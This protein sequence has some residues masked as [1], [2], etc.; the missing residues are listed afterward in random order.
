MY[1]YLVNAAG[2]SSSAGGDAV[3]ILRSWNDS[4]VLDLLEDVGEVGAV[5]PLL[6]WRALHYTCGMTGVRMGS[7]YTVRPLRLEQL[8]TFV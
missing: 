2:V 8:P 3:C 6:C 5:P 1:F 7:T 4:E